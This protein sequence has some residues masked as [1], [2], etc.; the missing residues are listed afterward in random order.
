MVQ[1]VYDFP[2]SETT[3]HDLDPTGGSGDLTLTVEVPHNQALILAANSTSGKNWSA[4]VTWQD[5]DGNEFVSESKGD[6]GLSSVSND[7]ARLVRKGPECKVTF[8][9]EAGGGTTNNLNAYVDAHR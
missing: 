4:S 1:P 7:W 5:S 2:E 6:I 9:S 8:T 3:G